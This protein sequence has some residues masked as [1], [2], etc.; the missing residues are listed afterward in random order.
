MAPW[1]VLVLLAVGGYFIGTFSP[2]VLISK[3]KAGYDIRTKGSGNAGTTNMLRM[4]GWQAGI[5][6]FVVDLAKGA[7][8]TLLGIYLSKRLGLAYNLGAYVAAGAV[9]LGH[10]FPVFNKF[11]GG[12][13]VATTGGIWLALMP[14][15]TLFAAVATI[16]I[17]LLTR[18][19]SI[20]SITAALGY[21]IVMFFLPSPPIPD[22]VMPWFSLAVGLFIIFLHRSNIR[23]LFRGEEKPLTIARKH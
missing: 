10:A 8:P 18:R 21:P 17:M 4:M 6:T 9:L 7:L 19:V 15:P 16:S 1:L 23:R 12:K 2:A 20:G 22:P 11:K 5:V 14:I 3:K 13:C